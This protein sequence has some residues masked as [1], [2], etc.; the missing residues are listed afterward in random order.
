MGIVNWFIE[1]Y[2]LLLGVSAFVVLIGSPIYWFFRIYYQK[3]IAESSRLRAL[4]SIERI[5]ALK[6]GLDEPEII[7]MLKNKY[8][9]A[10]YR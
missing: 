10:Y 1:N 7:E 6:K 4:E 3:I 2:E 5:K 8:K 9:K